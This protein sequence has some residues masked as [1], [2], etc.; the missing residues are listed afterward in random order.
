MKLENGL[1]MSALSGKYRIN[2]EHAASLMKLG[3]DFDLQFKTTKFII[4][5]DKTE[6]IIHGI[7]CLHYENLYKIKD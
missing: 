7:H 5:Q 3:P 6:K 2:D 4:S 1:N